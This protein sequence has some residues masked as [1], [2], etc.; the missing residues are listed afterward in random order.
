MSFLLP[1]NDPSAA[2][3]RRSFLGNSGLLLSGAA[4]ALV[5]GRETLAATRD[6][7]STAEDVRIL[8]SALKQ[9]VHFSK[10]V[11]YLRNFLFF[12]G[13]LFTIRGR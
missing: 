7:H 6:G 4:V 9:V 11:L 5:A 10:I 2:A 12:T 3:T 1:V 8:N 13:P